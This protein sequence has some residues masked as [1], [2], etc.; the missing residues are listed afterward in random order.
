MLLNGIIC[1]N[2]NFIPKFM[3][4][5]W[6][7][8]FFPVVCSVMRPEKIIAPANVGPLRFPKSSKLILVLHDLHFLEL[9][10]YNQGYLQKMMVLCNRVLFRSNIKRAQEIV[11]VSETQKNKFIAKLHELQIDT[12]ASLK[13]IYNSFDFHEFARFRERNE[14]ASRRIVI[15]TGKNHNK[16]SA[17]IK[18]FIEHLVTTRQHDDIA[19]EYEI[20]ILNCS[21]KD[22]MHPNALI[23]Y[24]RK[25]QKK[26]LFFRNLSRDDYLEVLASAK[27]IVVPSIEEGFG[28]IL[29]EASSLDIAILASDIDVFDEI[30]GIERK[31]F[32][33]LNLQEFLDSLSDSL[34]DCKNT[35]KIDFFKYSRSSF[36]TNW[37]VLLNETGTDHFNSPH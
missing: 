31:K 23:E 7:F 35:R 4:P 24:E 28:R 36:L 21:S 37:G 26:L 33:P 13:V 25:Y 34:L 1:V 22:L 30:L 5:L 10:K 2:Y 32:N 3:A 18:S 20:V 17:L 14:T 6:Y 15:A 8:I 16:N 19:R 12:S 9:V 27:L 11:F 29:I